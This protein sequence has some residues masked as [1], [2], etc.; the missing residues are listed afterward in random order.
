MKILWKRSSAKKLVDKP[1]LPKAAAKILVVEEDSK[2]FTQPSAKKASGIN[3]SEGLPMQASVELL[4]SYLTQQA[5]TA[6][7]KGTV[8]DARDRL[9]RLDK[10][11]KPSAPQTEALRGTCPDMCPEK[12]RYS[13]AEKRRLAVY[14]IVSGKEKVSH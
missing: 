4:R 3:L 1:K 13:R 5:C 10:E 9:V 7:E 6:A 14:E 2:P 8:L 12:E 11:N